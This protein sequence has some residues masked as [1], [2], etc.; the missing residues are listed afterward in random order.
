MAHRLEE[1]SLEVQDSAGNMRLAPLLYVSPSQINFQVPAGT[2][3]GEATLAIAG[4]PVAGMQVDA[5]APVLFMASYPNVTPAAT[6]VRVGSDEQ[7]TPVPVFRCF[8]PPT[9]GSVC[10][11][12]PIPLSGDEPVYV[13]FYGTGFRGATTANVTCSING[14]RRLCR[15]AKRPPFAASATGPYRDRVA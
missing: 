9:G 10:S 3:P 12:V 1:I 7:Q 4:T 6:A 15:S 5:L 14:V 8:S 13:S 2:A 11:P